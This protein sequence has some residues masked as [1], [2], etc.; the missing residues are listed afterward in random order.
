MSNERVYLIYEKYIRFNNK[1]NQHLIFCNYV[2][3]KKSLHFIFHDTYLK[4]NEIKN[5]RRHVKNEQNEN[6]VLESFINDF[7]TLKKNI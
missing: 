5:L 4:Q 1:F 7:K 6:K 3:K 2:H